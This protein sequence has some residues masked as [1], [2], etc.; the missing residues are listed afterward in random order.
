MF[1]CNAFLKRMGWTQKDLA[2]KLGVGTSTVGMWCLGK[3]TPAYAIIVELFRL[4][5][6]PEEL[7]GDD[8]AGKFQK[9]VTESDRDFEL[10]VKKALINI[11]Q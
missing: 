11:L 1:N 10:R 5:I 7:F 8:I 2:D 9:C 3:S 4:G 6:T